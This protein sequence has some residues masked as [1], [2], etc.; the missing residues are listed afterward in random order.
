MN[1]VNANLSS[2]HLEQSRRPV[3]VLAIRPRREV[4]AGASYSRCFIR[5]VIAVGVVMALTSCGTREDATENKG[6]GSAA[7]ESGESV[8]PKVSARFGSIV[9]VKGRVLSK[10]GIGD[11]MS[12]AEGVMTMEIKEVGGAQVDITMRCVGF[13]RD[14]HDTLA[15]LAGKTG[16]LTV[17]GYESVSATGAPEG[18]DKYVDVPATTGFAI[19]NIFVVVRILEN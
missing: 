8:R 17:T 14:T 19:E 12:E 18:L 5:I 2:L 6:T 13:E 15:R 16:M 10:S 9:Q 1:G 3:A 7:R 4:V 11:K